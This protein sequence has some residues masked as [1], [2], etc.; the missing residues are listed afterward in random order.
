MPMADRIYL[1]R[2]DDTP[3]GDTFFPEIINDEWQ[4]VEQEDFPADDSREFG[5]SFFTF[6]RS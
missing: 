1:T 5:F 6:D 3:E 2:V 4:V